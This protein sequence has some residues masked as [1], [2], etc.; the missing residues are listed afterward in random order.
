MKFLEMKNN[1]AI[2][3]QMKI[4]EQGLDCNPTS[5]EKGFVKHIT[6][7]HS[8][9]LNNRSEHRGITLILESLRSIDTSSK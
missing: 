7:M 1:I 6:N 4:L 9:G 2:M 3:I 5:H 8:T